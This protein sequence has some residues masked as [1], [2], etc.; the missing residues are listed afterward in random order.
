MIVHTVTY[1][2]TEPAKNL[3]WVFGP[4]RPQH[5][6]PPLAYLLLVMLA[7]PA[8]VY[9]PTHLLLRAVF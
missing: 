1:L 7:F 6:I 9:V 3:N 2:E 5:R 8:A 4:N